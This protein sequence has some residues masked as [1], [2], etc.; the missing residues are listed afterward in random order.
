MGVIVSWAALVG[1]S[2][3]WV[4]HQQASG[5]SVTDWSN[6]LQTLSFLVFLALTFNEGKQVAPLSWIRARVH[7]AFSSD[8]GKAH[9]TM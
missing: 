5:S 8:R 9:H 7:N 2:G 6:F 4:Q 1:V 3:C